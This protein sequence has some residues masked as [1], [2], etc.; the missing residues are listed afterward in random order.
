MGPPGPDRPRRPVLE[1]AGP[2]CD[3]SPASSAAGEAGPALLPG[4]RQALLQVRRVASVT[5]WARPSHSTA[6]SKLA[7]RRRPAPRLVSRLAT[8]AVAATAAAASSAVPQHLGRRAPPGWPGPAATASAPVTIRPVSS[9]SRATARPAT[10]GSSQ[11]VAMPGCMPSAVNG[12][13]SAGVLGG[14]PQVAGQRHRE[15]R[16]R[17]QPR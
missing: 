11:V 5:A 7:A 16:R 15:A 17:R 4:G 13:P 14:V 3:G 9:R 1:P 2:R 10:S 12:A 8:G 6:A